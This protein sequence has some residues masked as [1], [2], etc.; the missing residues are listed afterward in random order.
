MLR[1]AVG[2]RIH[3]LPTAG[4]IP[5]VGGECSTTTNDCAS[6]PSRAAADWS[7]HSGYVRAGVAAPPMGVLLVVDGAQP[8][9]ATQ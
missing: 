7:G 9:A 6:G 3:G 8:C 1:G 2:K 5:L 4:F